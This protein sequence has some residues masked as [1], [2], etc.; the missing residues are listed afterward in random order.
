MS[1]PA[2]PQAP[3]VRSATLKTGVARITIHGVPNEPGVAARIFG[4]IGGRQINVDDIIHSTSDSGRN[5]IVSFTVDGR[6]ADAARAAA[7]GIATA[8]GP[9]TTVEMARDLARLRVVGMGMRAQSGVAAR[10]FQALAAEGINIENISTSEIAI[11]L[12][13]ALRDGERALQAVQRAFGLEQEQ[14]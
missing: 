12:L 8:F 11:S 4:E 5:V 6:Q 10:I 9:A 1:E 3:A 2:E 14:E 13:V 7:E